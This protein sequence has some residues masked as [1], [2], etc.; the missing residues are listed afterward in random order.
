[1]SLGEP[2]TAAP[3]ARDCVQASVRG[4]AVEP[5]AKR[6]AS[7]EPPDATPGAKERLL[8]QI[9]GVVEGAEHAIAVQLQLPAVRCGETLKCIAITV[10]GECQERRIRI[11]STCPLG[12]STAHGLCPT[13]REL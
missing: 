8:N 7:F 3:A 2:P 9:L 11:G 13:R 1:M 5:G 10:P 12:D 4:D 6:N